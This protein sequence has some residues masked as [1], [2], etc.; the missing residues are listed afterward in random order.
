M[1]L[2][3]YYKN[4]IQLLPKSTVNVQFELNDKQKL[5]LESCVLFDLKYEIESNLLDDDILQHSKLSLQ[6]DIFIIEITNTS[7]KNLRIYNTDNPLFYI[8]IEEKLYN[9]KVR[10]IEV[11][12][13]KPNL[14]RRCANQFIN[15]FGVISNIR[16]KTNHAISWIQYGRDEKAAAT[17]VFFSDLEKCAKKMFVMASVSFFIGG[18]CFYFTDN[19]KFANHM[20]LYSYC[21]MALQHQMNVCRAIM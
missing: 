8:N 20:M 13:V 3:L 7:D 6:K 19:K 5:I 10:N 17:R 12:N 18:V 14:I 9:E 4:T 16:Q 11:K 2:E 21:I 1:K 15:L